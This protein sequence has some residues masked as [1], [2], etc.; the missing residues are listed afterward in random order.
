M[1]TLLL[2]ALKGKNISRPPVWLMRQAGRYM[3]SYRAM[4]EKYSLMTL[5]TEP[6]LITKITLLPIDELHVDAAIL[7]SDIL[8]IPKALGFNLRFDDQKG[9]IFDDPLSGPLDL[10][11]YSSKGL[12]ERLR[13]LRPAIQELKKQL[14]VP[15]IG[16]AGAPFTLACYLMNHQ[17]TKAWAYKDPKSFEKIIHMLEEAVII[18]LKEQIDAGCDAVQLFDTWANVLSEEHFHTWCLGPLKRIVKSLGGNTPLIFF[19]R[20]SSYLAETIEKT[21]VSAISVDWLRPIHHIRTLLPTTPLQGNL[22]PEALYMP[23]KE[24]IQ[25]TRQI[26]ASMHRDPAYIFNLG[27]GILPGVPYQNIKVLVETVA[28]YE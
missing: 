4:R 21:G 3:P 20:G 17:G 10:E 8:M 14:S 24:L 13:F 15:L 28:S 27:H 6:E 26:L 11:K 18:S 16:F 2:D 23:E 7:F 1:N 5:F 25:K 9:P 12:L 19:C 22:D